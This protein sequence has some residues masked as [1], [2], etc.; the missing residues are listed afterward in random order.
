MPRRDAEIPDEVEMDDQ[1][2]DPADDIIAYL[3]E[4]S[5]SISIGNIDSI[6]KNEIKLENLKMEFYELSDQN[7]SES[8]KIFI[9]AKIHHLAVLLYSHLDKNPLKV[10]PLSNLY[11][12]C[13]NILSPPEEKSAKFIL[14][15][16]LVSL[17]HFML[18][19]YMV[20]LQKKGKIKKSDDLKE[21]AKALM[22]AMEG[23]EEKKK[24]AAMIQKNLSG[25]R[26][27]HPV[28]AALID[29]LAQQ[30]FILAREYFES[31]SSILQ[32]QKSDK[33]LDTDELN[34][35]LVRC[36]R[37]CEYTL[38]LVPASDVPTI[39]FHFTLLTLQT[40]C[41]ARIILFRPLS[42][43]EHVDYQ[44][45]TIGVEYL[46]HI[47]LNKSTSGSSSSS[48]SN[49]SS[50]SS[51]SDSKIDM[52]PQ[53]D[54]VSDIDSALLKKFCND[55]DEKTC[56]SITEILN[57]KDLYYLTILCSYVDK[58]GQELIDSASYQKNRIIEKLK[59]DENIQPH[60]LVK[61]AKA[62]IENLKLL[63][64]EIE[65]RIIV[66]QSSGSNNSFEPLRSKCNRLL[67]ELSMVTSDNNS[68]YSDSSSLFEGV[69]SSR[70]VS[71]QSTSSNSSSFSNSG[72]TP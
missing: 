42:D 19:R 18:I 39:Q 30:F 58:M 24:H 10:G 27:D 55:H 20:L 48:S 13:A 6:L 41:Y 43:I 70:S 50:S 4:C 22:A 28:E 2:S 62:P 9:V 45:K 21:D 66:Q 36:Y 34:N 67:F 46:Q 38:T 37:S 72:R 61:L 57:A 35:Q 59:E 65:A 7:P 12:D 51:L 33:A 26:K 3:K 52:K 23:F 17:D 56:Q 60:M 49:S 44:R 68:S 14:V 29:N 69:N 63:M 64:D 54:K 15:N 8:K 16:Q 11:L 5:E 25:L 53:T 32:K 47:L 40:N 71:S 1:E 31:A